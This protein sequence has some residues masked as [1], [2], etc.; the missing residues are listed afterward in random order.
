MPSSRA[1]GF[2]PFTLKRHE[3][4]LHRGGEPIPL[5]ERATDLLLA[6]V[7]NGARVV[8]KN[9]LMARAW[10]DTVIDESTLRFHIAS[11]RK[12]LGDDSTQ[13]RYIVNVS[14]RG[15]CF[16]AAVE[17]FSALPAPGSM[18]MGTSMTTSTPMPPAVRAARLIGRDAALADLERRLR[19]RRFVSIVAAGGMGK[20][21]IAFALAEKLRRDFPDGVAVL[22]VSVIVDESQVAPTLAHQLGLVYAAGGAAEALC[23]WFQHRQALVLLDNCET[24][25]EACALLAKAILQHA[26]GVHLLTTSR[27]ALRVLGEW[28]LQLKPLTCPP[29]PPLAS[30]PLLPSYRLSADEARSFS[31]V[32]LALSLAS[33]ARPGFA[34]SEAELQ[35]LCELVRR[36][37]GMPLAIELTLAQLASLDLDGIVSQLDEKLL[38]GRGPV[39]GV[40]DRHRTLK[41]LLDWSYE[42]LTGDEQA[43]LRRLSVCNGPFTLAAAEAVAA[44]HALTEDQVTRAVMGLGAKS[45]LT[46]DGGGHGITY[47]QLDSTRAYATH[48]LGDG[49]EGRQARVQQCVYLHDLMLRAERQ[50][51]RMSLADWMAEFGPANNDMRACIAWAFGAH[52]DLIR[53]IRLVAASI[54]FAHQMTLAGEYGGHVRRA[55]GALPRLS[56]P[57]P[58]LE[59]RLLEGLSLLD[60]LSRGVSREMT[61]T[62]ARMLS[63]ATQLG[64]ERLIIQALNSHFVTRFFGE[65]DYPAAAAVQSEISGIAAQSSDAAE[66]EPL[67]ERLQLQALHG[68]GRH[69]AAR[70]PLESRLLDPRPRQRMRPP[71]PVDMTVMTRMLLVRIHWLQGRADD[72]L[73]LVADLRFMA[74]RDVRFALANACAWSICPLHLWCGDESRAI[75]AIDEMHR[76]AA[77]LDIPFVAAWACAFDRAR[78]VRFGTPRR[79][80]DGPAEMREATARGVV[81]EL[82]GTVHFSLVTPALREGLRRGTLGWATPEILRAVGETRLLEGDVA[83]ARAAFVQARRVARQHGALA[84]ELRAATSLARL[85]LR[86][87]QPSSARSVL[88]P[89]LAR[90]EQGWRTADVLEAQALLDLQDVH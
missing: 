6:L 5:G 31:A 27:E 64:N 7:E 52:G 16:V 51:S 3:R 73:D 58:E 49:P 68:L 56:R 48:R 57:E 74:E 8:S 11:L 46:I 10:P 45:L 90:F 17:R 84:W 15:Y 9:D 88:E 18:A 59:L 39:D 24:Q 61:T 78:A 43:V 89:V 69:E 76:Q 65:G 2:G 12:A 79:L 85:H 38:L 87:A 77:L 37:D 80:P 34:P 54:G 83:G 29:R 20:S 14:G 23:R 22:D 19:E 72:A 71:F 86:D 81:A 33:A 55:L 32:E 82:L 40:I 50:R 67:L 66:Y 35:L 42:R 41:A 28:V 60:I 26:P 70:R 13:S 30:H 44:D 1:Y 62:Q 4:S 21:T 47:R 53:G 63:L 25:V 75:A 36:L